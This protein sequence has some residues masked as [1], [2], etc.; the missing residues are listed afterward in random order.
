[1]ADTKLNAAAGI[2]IYSKGFMQQR[3]NA[4]PFYCGRPAL[5][6]RICATVAAVSGALYKI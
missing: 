6:S 3:A 1:M 4:G 2:G 5:L